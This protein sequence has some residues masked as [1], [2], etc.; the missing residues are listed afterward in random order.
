[1]DDEKI[2]KNG[3]PPTENREVRIVETGETFKNYREAA[4]AIGGNRSCIYLCLRGYRP[5]HLGYTFE[6]VEP[7]EEV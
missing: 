5:H 3:R 4:E 2:K 1:M 6:Y 7:E